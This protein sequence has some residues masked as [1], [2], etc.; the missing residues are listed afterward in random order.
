[1]KTGG[2]IM[3][4]AMNAAAQPIGF[5]VPL[6]GFNEASPASQSTTRNT[7]KLAVS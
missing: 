7:P 4:L 3:V 1:M 2:G 5:P 6:D